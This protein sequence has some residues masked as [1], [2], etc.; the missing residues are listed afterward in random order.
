MSRQATDWRRRIV[1]ALVR[2]E[3]AAERADLVYSHE[4]A[5][6]R[7]VV[8]AA[9]E[10]WKEPYVYACYMEFGL[11]PAKLIPA[12]AARRAQQTWELYRENVVE[13]SQIRRPETGSGNLYQM[14]K[15][16]E[17]A[18]E[19]PLRCLSGQKQAAVA[20]D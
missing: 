16:P 4:Y 14:P 3:G 8:N 18:V 2:L 6:A 7:R 20:G 12:L 17:P 5:F 15:S 11:H 1:R 13:T 19:K 10:G 9:H